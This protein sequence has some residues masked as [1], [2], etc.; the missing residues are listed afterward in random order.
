[1][2]YNGLATV[3]SLY[4]YCMNITN[5]SFTSSI[6]N[7]VCF[8]SLQINFEVN[9]WRQDGRGGEKLKGISY[10]VLHSTSFC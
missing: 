5:L 10:T 7:I 9:I 1:M 6:H 8:V 2:S 3:V 4:K